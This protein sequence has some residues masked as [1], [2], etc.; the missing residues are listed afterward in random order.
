MGKFIEYA[1]RFFSSVML[2]LA[3]LCV[4]V[5]FVER[6]TGDWGYSC[7]G[8]KLNDCTD[9]V[10]GGC[11]LMGITYDCK[12]DGVPILSCRYTGG[13]CHWCNNNVSTCNGGCVDATGTPA[14]HPN[15]QCSRV[16]SVSGCRS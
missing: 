1:L 13:W 10:S 8:T 14:P 5:G 4:V 3:I 9:V 15:A 6:A 7:T 12:L 16:T 2:L 11:V